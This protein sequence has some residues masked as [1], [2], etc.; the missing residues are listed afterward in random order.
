MR[1]LRGLINELRSVMPQAKALTEA[2][3]YDINDDAISNIQSNGSIDLGAG[4]GLLSHQF[5]KVL[6]PY[7]FEVG[8][9]AKWA[10]FVEW[11][12]GKQVK[13]P[14][15]LQSYA[16]QF[17]GPYPGTWDEFEENIE[18]WLGRHGIDKSKKYML[19][20][21]ILE[22]GLKAKPFLW[23][24]YQ[25]NKAKLIAQIKSLLR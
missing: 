13:V 18:A 22:R 17:K 1:E 10:P 9:S 5:V 2:A 23:P 7:T 21:A 8:N 14:A 4:G 20:N 19:M 3:A 12:T 24:A 6:N 11:G 25:K 15:E 16:N